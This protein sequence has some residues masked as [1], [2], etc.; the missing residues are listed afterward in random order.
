MAIK[1]TPLPLF[2]VQW[3]DLTRPARH[4]RT[5]RCQLPMR[6]NIPSLKDTRYPPLLPISVF[7]RVFAEASLHRHPS[8]DVDQKETTLPPRPGYNH[9]TQ[10]PD[11]R[12]PCTKIAGGGGV[13]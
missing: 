13:K 5:T 11:C 2:P 3:S 4:N 8:H 1:K 7:N 10:D 12:M 6:Q 9:G